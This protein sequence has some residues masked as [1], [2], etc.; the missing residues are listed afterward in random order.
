MA[1]KKDKSWKDALLKTSM[2]LE[3]LVTEKLNK[4][5]FGIQGEFH[6]LRPNE[7]EVV[8]EFSIDIWAM[9]LFSKK[10]IG[11]WASLNYL[12]ECKY[13]H[14]GV[15]WVFAP[16]TKSDTEHLI[17]VGIIHALDNLCTRQIF[18]K[19]SLW[20]LDNRFSLCFKGVEVHQ[21]DALTQN[22]ERG[23]SQIR[24]GLPRLAIHLSEVQMMM[25][26]DE[27]LNIEYICPMLVTTADLYVLKDNLKF[28]D[29]QK[30]KVI[31]Q[32]ASKVDALI[33]TT[34]YSHLFNSYADKIISDLHIKSPYIQER[35]D[36]LAI[37]K[38][39]LTKV[40]DNHSKVQKLIWFDWDIKEISNRILVVNY[41]YLEIINQLIRKAIIK[42]GKSL[43]RVGI[44]Q[45]NIS[46]RKTWVSEYN[47]IKLKK[48]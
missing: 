18:D 34:P 13:C 35:L 43:T 42:S 24:Y 6:Y 17:P 11:I 40:D 27:D 1:E 46:Q 28:S 41:D 30:A 5:K 26:N 16:H 14:P 44:L 47:G 45:K 39:K 25:F 2:P 21:K 48:I 33:L 12:I 3:Y 31:T 4:L 9:K 15:K 36:Q 29:F 10:D 7:Q 20:E 23:I 22:I 38:K 32:I 19:S 8:T 37:L